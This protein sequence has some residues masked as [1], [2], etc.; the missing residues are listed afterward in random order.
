MKK[1]C[2]FGHNFSVGIDGMNVYRVCVDC[3]KTVYSVP[4][5]SNPKCPKCGEPI[6]I[7]CVECDNCKAEFEYK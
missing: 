2:L 6:P 5:G 3:G 1:I 7:N 4:D